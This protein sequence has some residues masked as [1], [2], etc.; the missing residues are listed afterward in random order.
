M[1]VE[2]RKKV[3]VGNMLTA[4]TAAVGTAL[5]AVT[6]WFSSVFS[7]IGG[8]LYDGTNLTVIGYLIV[9]PVAIGLVVF[10]VKLVLK[11]IN[12]IKA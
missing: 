6:G 2:R 7:N 9:I 8:I 3:E 4:F 10:G 12:K 11:L 1:F 5:T